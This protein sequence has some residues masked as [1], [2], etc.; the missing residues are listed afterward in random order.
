[1]PYANVDPDG[2]AQTGAIAPSTL[3][4]A[5]AVYVMTGFELVTGDGS[6]STGFVVSVTTTT[7][8]PLGNL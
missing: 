8:V 1:V 6:V 4:F 5:V 3:S 7:N 2:G